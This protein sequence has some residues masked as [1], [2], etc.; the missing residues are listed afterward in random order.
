MRCRFIHS[1]NRVIAISSYAGKP[2]K[3]IASCHEDDTFDLEFGKNLASAKLDLKILERRLKDAVKQRD[4]LHVST[5]LMAD[6]AKKADERVQRIVDELVKSEYAY[7]KLIQ[8]DSQI[9]DKIVD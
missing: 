4:Q 9:L 7:A 6:K 3:A 1:G 8:P 5:L 2:I